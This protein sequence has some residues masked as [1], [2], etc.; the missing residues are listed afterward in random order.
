LFGIDEQAYASGY[1]LSL[2]LLHEQDDE[3][4]TETILHNMV[5][6]FAAAARPS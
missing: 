5:A 2:N 3:A 6:H 4:V 1:T